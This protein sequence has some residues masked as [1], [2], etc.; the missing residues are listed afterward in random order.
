LSSF[1]YGR[2]WTIR[3]GGVSIG[4]FSRAVAAIAGEPAPAAITTSS[5]TIRPPDVSTPPILPLVCI[6]AVTV[7]PVIT[8]APSRSA[9]AS[10]VCVAATGSAT[11]SSA[12]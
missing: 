6:S 3:P 8:R 7:V 9:S 12:T 2:E 4:S 1:S 5:A 11:P 10:S